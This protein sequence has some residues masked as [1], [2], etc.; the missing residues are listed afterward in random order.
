MIKLSS[1]NLYK[2]SNWEEVKQEVLKTINNQPEDKLKE[3]AIDRLQPV[4]FLW[5][6]DEQGNRYYPPEDPDEMLKFHDEILDGNKS[7]HLRMPYVQ[8]DMITPD[9]TNIPMSTTI[10]CIEPIVLYLINERQWDMVSAI[11]IA[12]S[13]CERCLNILLEDATGEIYTERDNWRE[14]KGPHT[15]CE[16][17]SIID[18]EYDKWYKEVWE[19][20]LKE[21]KDQVLLIEAEKL[22]QKMNSQEMSDWILQNNLED[23]YGKLDYN[24]AKQIANASPEWNLNNMSLDNFDIIVE[25]KNKNVN[26]LPPIVLNTNGSYEILDGKHRIGVAKYNN[27]E[28]IQVYLGKI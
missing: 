10:N 8:E 28:S 9:G 19:P 14:N 27:E 24:D 23:A 22:P 4:P 25:P 2:F 7:Q 20:S 16:F 11:V 5:Y 3:K 18:P 21:K 15:Y 17:C 12:G 6:E 26:N 1:K 13:T